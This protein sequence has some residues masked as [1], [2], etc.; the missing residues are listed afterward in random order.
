MISLGL[1]FGEEV[2][3]T[4]PCYQTNVWCNQLVQ[5]VKKGIWS[6]EYKKNEE[7]VILQLFHVDYGKEI[8]KN[9]VYDRKEI[10]TELGVDSGTIGVFDK[11]YYEK[12]HYPNSIDEEWYN[13]YVCESDVNNHINITNS[14]GV[15]VSTFA[16]D[17]EY[18]ATLFYKDN[19]VCGIQIVC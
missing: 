9:G 16:G 5:D 2:Y 17:G 13:K 3:I 18:Y 10:S 12:Y 8:F 7:C 15:F 6:I 19:K 4:D 14:Y 11:D 1:V